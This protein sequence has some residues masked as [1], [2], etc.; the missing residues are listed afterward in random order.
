MDAAGNFIVAFSSSDG[1]GLGA[2]TR[3]YDAAGNALT[4]EVQVNT[5]TTGDQTWTNVVMNA[6]GAYVVSWNSAGQD[7][8]G[9]GIY[10]RRY[11]A[12]GVAQG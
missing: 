7:G 9:D 12:N 1:N 5:A 2:Y 8:S 4:G 3:R 6:S 11:D 10:A